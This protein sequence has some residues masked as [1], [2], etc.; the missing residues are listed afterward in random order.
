VLEGCGGRVNKSALFRPAT[1]A[2][3]CKQLSTQ[4]Q[5]G[6]LEESVNKKRMEECRTVFL[7]EGL[8][9]G[10]LFGALS[11]AACMI[12]PRYMSPRALK[13]FPVNLRVFLTSA[14]FVAGF[15]A[16][17]EPASNHCVRDPYK[18]PVERVFKEQI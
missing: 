15:W 5:M 4:T 17:G 1:T 3:R 12:A 6:S 14:G 11:M 13:A 9:M 16:G 7:Q 2:L 18:K 10:L 8:K